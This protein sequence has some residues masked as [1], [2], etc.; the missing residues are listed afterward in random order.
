MDNSRPRVP[1]AVAMPV[2][3]RRTLTPA[4][5]GPV[6][7]QVPGIEFEHGLSMFAHAFASVA[8]QTVKPAGGINVAID[9]DGGTP[10]RGA[11]PTRQAALNQALDNLER[12]ELLPN[13]SFVSFIDDDDLWYPHHL[14][15]HHRM[16]TEG[17][18]G[19]V[20]YSWFDG[21]DPFPK[22]RGRVFDS[23]EPHHTTMNITVRAD[24]ARE[25]GKM[26]HQP[27]G[28]MHQEWS[29]EDWQMI[30]KLVELGARFVGTGE[31]TFHYRVHYGNTSGLPTKGDAV[32]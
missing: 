3:H 2:L 21:N 6:A 8:R 15:T 14:E 9:G 12:L 23:K 27:D 18:G 10:T 32:S 4:E 26:L 17:G 28:P 16:L 20:A 25:A 1:V 30:L 11:G 24:L 5:G 13:R 31:I 7:Y 22:H 19:D 29:G